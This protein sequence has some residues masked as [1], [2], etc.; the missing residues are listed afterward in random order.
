VSGVPFV[1]KLY[2]NGRCLITDRCDNIIDHAPSIGPIDD[3]SSV[4]K[5]EFCS[6]KARLSYQTVPHRPWPPPL[7]YGHRG[8]SLPAPPHTTISQHYAGLFYVAAPGVGHHGGRCRPFRSR[9]V[10]CRQTLW[11]V[12]TC[13]LLGKLASKHTTSDHGGRLP[14]HRLSS[15]HAESVDS[16]RPPL[17]HHGGMIYSSGVGTEGGIRA[18]GEVFCSMRFLASIDHGGRCRPTATTGPHSRRES[19]QQSADMLGNRLV[20]LKLEKIS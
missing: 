5:I 9:R 3:V 20:S 15:L 10:D 1:G 16:S 17:E 7:S 12:V 13:V 19:I 2:F 14:S 6:V 18:G 4:E 11:V 8:A